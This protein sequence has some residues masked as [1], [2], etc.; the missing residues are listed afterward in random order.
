MSTEHNQLGMINKR[1]KFGFETAYFLC[2]E[3]G[4]TSSFVTN[5]IDMP[6]VS[7]FYVALQVTSL[8]FFSD[9]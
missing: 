9:K 5:F 2:N 6:Y 8:L 3:I 7:T 4:L 1:R